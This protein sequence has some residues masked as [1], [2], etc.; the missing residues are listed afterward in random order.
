MRLIDFY[1]AHY[2]L[3]RPLP[4]EH[5]RK[6]KSLREWLNKNGYDLKNKE[7]EDYLAML[8]AWLDMKSTKVKF[9]SVGA[10]IPESEK[11]DWTRYA[12]SAG[13][14]SVADMIKCLVR[15]KIDYKK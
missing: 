2:A 6:Y 15:E 8:N 9:V 1:T 10:R 4:T 3:E 14:A 12:K 11:E 5:A 7:Y 13:Y